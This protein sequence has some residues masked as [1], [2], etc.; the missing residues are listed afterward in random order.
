MR[1]KTRIKNVTVLALLSLTVLACTKDVIE[2][3]VVP[4][5]PDPDPEPPVPELVYLGVNPTIAGMEVVATRGIITQ[6]TDNDR[7]GLFLTNG[8][9]GSNYQDDVNSA[10]IPATYR[11]GWKVDREISITESGVAYGYYPY[12]SKVTDGTAVPV[13]IASQT[14][15]L[16][17]RKATVNQDNPVA[18]IGMKHALALVSVRIRKNDYQHE[19]K[20]TKVEVLDVQ[21]SGT[22]NI[23]TGKVTGSGSPATYSV[24]PN[25][26]LDDSELEKTK[27]IML[28][29]VVGAASG[30]MRFQI[31]VDDKIYVWDIPKSH[32]WEAGKEYT[33][34]LNLG[35]VP[36]EHPDLELD[37]DYWTNYGKDDNIQ[38][39]D[40]THPGSAY[41]R[42]VDV[43]N[44]D[45]PCGR[46]IVSGE[47][48][49]F[50]GVVNSRTES[51]KGRIKYTLWQGDKLVEQFP[52]YS[53]EC[54]GKNYFNTLTIP[55]FVTVAPGTYRLK[56]LLKEEGK[57]T[58][59]IPS[60]RYSEERDW[61]F[62]VQADNTIP[63]IKSMNLEGYTSAYNTIHTVKFN[64]PFNM[65]Y[66]MTNRANVPLKGE[67]KAVWHRTFTGEF[68]A[69]SNDDGQ[70]WED[71]IGRMDINVSA[72]IKE[73]KGKLSCR[74]TKERTEPKKYCPQISFY[75]KAEGTTTWILMRS[76]SDSE[77]QRWKEADIDKI[78][79]GSEEHPELSW[80]IQGGFNYQYITLE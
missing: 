59:I 30:N 50:R 71:E 38:I 65:E 20:L 53:F 56:I 61:M 54:K 49:A 51:F 42:V 39:E 5:T 35:K 29:A 21:H 79:S 64:T 57:N 36:E 58:W 60:D 74:I 13:E 66:A 45:T 27:M 68:N 23:A 70:A 1:M 67:I 63:S 17:A 73:Y 43:E 12:S 32:I 72:D 34:T 76:D 62:T 31:T 10:N 2:L 22:M 6:F 26:H 55:C 37:V 46:I 14:D 48:Y 44:D 16:Y 69:N 7:I 11:G 77:L 78:V 47:S 75:Y 28:P 3:P 8:E 9:L 25:L 41:Y 15:Y 18:E 40:H 19:G 33:Y 52:S 4:P 24:E 80:I